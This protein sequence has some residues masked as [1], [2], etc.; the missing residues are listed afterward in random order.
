MTILITIMLFMTGCQ[1]QI[2]ESIHSKDKAD[3][4]EIVATEEQSVQSEKETIHQTNHKENKQKEKKKTTSNKKHSLSPLTIHYIDVG[5]ADATLFTFDEHAILFDT[6]DWKRNDT[7]DYLEQMG[8]TDL[9]LIII[10]HPD[11]DHIGQ[12]PEIIDTFHVEEVWMS[13][14]ESSS[15]V[16]QRSIESILNHDINYHE[17]QVGESFAIGDLEMVVVYP[18]NKTGQTNEESLS[19]FFTYGSHHFLFTGDADSKA[20]SEML[21]INENLRADVLHIGHHGS[22]TSSGQ[23]FI[24]AVKPKIAIIS[25]GADNSYGHPHPDVLKRLENAGI[26]IY[27][28]D[29]HGTIQ[30]TTDGNNYSIKTVKAKTAKKQAP[31]SKKETTNST[32]KKTTTKNCIDINEASISELQ[33]IIHIGSDRAEQMIEF[34]PFSSVDELSKVNGIGPSRLQDIKNEGLACTN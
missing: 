4:A 13:G 22:N 31:S 33:Q 14:N 26:R 28:T 25:V 9:D 17:P 32:K 27:R 6:G 29:L 5:Q 16:F 7:I 8:I 19:V 15:Q 11:A 3:E 34:R 10:S 1:L 21:Q 12:L 30:L 20:E 18:L 23:S 24:H 2:D